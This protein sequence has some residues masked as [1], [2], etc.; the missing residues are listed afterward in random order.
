MQ[1][2]NR[3]PLMR[4]AWVFNATQLDGLPAPPWE[5]APQS[6]A[7]GAAATDAWLQELGVRIVEGV[8]GVAA[9]SG[10]YALALDTIFMMPRNLF[11]SDLAWYSTLFHELAHWSGHESR[12]ARLYPGLAQD[13]QENAREELR[14]EIAAWMLCQVCRTGFKPREHLGYLKAYLALLENDPAEI[15]RAPRDASAIGQFL[16]PPMA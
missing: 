12:L 13:P 11:R 6:P 16:Q 3:T 14:A 9:G 7:A 1:E 15:Y 5:T 8:S 10:A 2:K 4:H